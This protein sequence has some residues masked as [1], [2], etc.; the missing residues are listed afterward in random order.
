MNIGLI[1]RLVSAAMLPTVLVVALVNWRRRRSGGS[2]DKFPR[3]TDERGLEIL[4][5][6]ALRDFLV[7]GGDPRLVSLRSARL[8]GVDLSS[9]NLERVD[10]SSAS[11]RR[12]TLE[13]AR[14]VRARLD[15]ADLAN[16][17]LRCADLAGASLLDANLWRADLRGTNLGE[18]GSAGVANLRRA[19]YDKTTRWPPGF[20]PVL[21]G[22]V[23]AARG[24][25]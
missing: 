25:R 18:C 5:R 16:A 7:L 1:A 2:L 17:D 8:D 11:L 9:R 19:R 6:R 3:T 24:A 14:L 15:Y 20:D 23:V 22:A 21:A 13:R 10:L 12:S 4:G